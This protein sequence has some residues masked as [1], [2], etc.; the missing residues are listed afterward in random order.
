MT[1]RG[2]TLIDHGSHG[3]DNN[4][5]AGGG[6]HAG[7]AMKPVPMGRDEPRA[8]A[9]LQTD[10]RELEPATTLSTRIRPRKRN[11][12]R[13]SSCRERDPHGRRLAGAPAEGA[14][15]RQAG[16]DRAQLHPDDASRRLLRAIRR[17]HFRCSRWCIYAPKENERRDEGGLNRHSG[18]ILNAWGRQNHRAS[19]GP[20]AS[21]LAR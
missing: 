18:L 13:R 10:D 21:A 1:A 5:V 12:E 9:R 2:S 6:M 14:G 16:A 19:A 20:N 17:R 7:R 15:M 11:P 4:T 3:E 8:D